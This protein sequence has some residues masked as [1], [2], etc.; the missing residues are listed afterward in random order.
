MADITAYE[1]WKN[2]QFEKRHFFDE[3]KRQAHLRQAEFLAGGQ[4]DPQ[5]INHTLPEAFEH[6]ASLQRVALAAKPQAPAA[7]KAAKRW[8]GLFG[9]PKTATVEPEQKEQHKP[10]GPK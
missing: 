5:P 10:R 1:Q 6:L 3:S 9:A 7:D 4:F 2:T 8:F